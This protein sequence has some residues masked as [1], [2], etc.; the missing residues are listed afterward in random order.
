MIKEKLKEIDAKVDAFAK[1]HPIAAFS[2][3]CGLIYAGMTVVNER[4]MEVA[5]KKGVL[6]ALRRGTFRVKKPVA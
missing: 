5:V 4:A 3:C 1:E 2:I 6:E